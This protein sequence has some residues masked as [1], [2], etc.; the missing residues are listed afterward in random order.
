MSVLPTISGVLVLVAALGYAV[1]TVFMKMAATS[2]SYPAFVIIA[3]ALTAAVIAE[4]VIL[5]RLSLGIAYIAILATET[6]I[7]LG[8]STLIGEELAP[9]E[10]AGAALVL[11]GTIILTV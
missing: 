3:L 9:R 5:Q 1:A 10:M 11:V 8:F 7:I 2:Q 4:V 6:L